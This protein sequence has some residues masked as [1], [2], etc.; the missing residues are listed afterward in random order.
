MTVASI[1]ALY[2]KHTSDDLR[3]VGMTTKPLLVRLSEHIDAAKNFRGKA[4]N[5]KWIRSVL[6]GGEAPGIRLLEAVPMDQRQ[7]AECAWIAKLNRSGRLT[8]GTHGGEGGRLHP[9]VC[10]KIRA[11][12]TGRKHTPERVLKMRASQL[13]KKHTVE[14]RKNMSMSHLGHVTSEE[15][16]AKLRAANVGKTLS[17]EHRAKL[18]AANIGKKASE[19]SRIKMQL[20]QRARRKQERNAR[21]ESDT[22]KGTA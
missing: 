11:T 2:D 8:N 10:D 12:L 13:G 19:E 3:Y 17:A 6:R 18:R 7:K 16:R 1:Y 4:R 15:T 14:A 21:R 20:F 5:H 9:E 22:V